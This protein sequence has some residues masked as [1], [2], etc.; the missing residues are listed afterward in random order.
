MA[1][2]CTRLRLCW[3]RTF[4]AYAVKMSRLATHLTIFWRQLMPVFVAIQWLNIHICTRNY[5]VAGSILTPRISQGS[6]STYFRWSGHFMYIFVKGLFR[7][8][9]TSFH[10]SIIFDR[11]RAKDKSARFFLQLCTWNYHKDQLLMGANLFGLPC[12][13]HNATSLTVC[14]SM[15]YTNKL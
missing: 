12:T 4:W 8:I 3:R 11:P 7:D 5:S 1:S 15:I 6:A 9:P 14:T 2:A 10:C 13:W